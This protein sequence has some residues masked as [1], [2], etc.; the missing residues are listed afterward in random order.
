[1]DKLS[2]LTQLLLPVRGLIFDFDGLL[3]NS[4]KYHFRAYNDVFS[5][6]GHSLDKTEYSKYW[7]SLGHGVRG[8]IERHN[9]DLDPLEIRREKMPIFSRYCEDG[10]ITLF[11]EAKEIIELLS[12]SGRTMAIASGTPAPDI[13]AVLRNAE[14][15]DTFEVIMGSD[16]VPKIK[17]APDIFLETLEAIGLQA[18]ECVVFED[19]EKGMFAAIEAKIP[20]IIIRTPE[21]KG[22]DFSR[23]DLCVDS[24][25]EMVRL[26]REIASTRTP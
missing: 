10:S 1:M 7:T 6:H 20:V 19:A 25:S 11:D 14:I 4:E 22:F 26:L 8:E 24:H 9:L 21:T 5:R 12:G 2:T 16:T 13:R 23:A 18:N 17:P 15:G 3:A